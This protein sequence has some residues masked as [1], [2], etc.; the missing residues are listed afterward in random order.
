MATIK[1]V[2]F[3]KKV[4]GQ[5]TADGDKNF[6]Q[7]DVKVVIKAIGEVLGTEMAAG[8]K[9][10]AFEGIQFEGVQRPER[11]GRNPK[12]GETLTVAA[13]IGAKA[14]FTKGFKDLV[15]GR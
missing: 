10:K 1:N 3:I 4:A 5:A 7:K 12:T 14:S 11:T 13:H 9:I 8:N 2:E 6:T 15:A